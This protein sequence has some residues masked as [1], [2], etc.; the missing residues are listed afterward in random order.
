VAASLG[1]DPEKILEHLPALHH[2]LTEGL[3]P[4]AFNPQLYAAAR[5]HAEDM[6]E[7][8]YYSHDSQDGRTYEDRIRDTG[9]D[10]V[11][12][13]QFMGLQCLGSDSDI[14]ESGARLDRLVFLMFKQ[15]FT[16]E[17]N[18]G[19]G[20][21][22]ILNPAFKE[23]GV[24]VIEGTSSEL[25]GICGDDLLFTVADFGLSSAGPVP[26]IVGVVY[27]DMDQDLLCSP[28]EGV[29]RAYVS[30]EGLSG[31]NT[32]RR[33]TLYANEAGGFSLPALPGEYR[34]SVT[35]DGYQAVE[36]VDIEV[37]EENE[38]ILLGVVRS[39]PEENNP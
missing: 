32:S 3:P 35:A 19:A 9:Y 31:D 7:N 17:L 15:I 11:V 10:P 36:A 29:G 4:L 20:E 25:G 2:I 6:L 30:V 24:G 16:Y 37:G 38:A 22:S 34:I 13:G 1:M 27:S 8:G 14:D 18:P 23:V 12:M 21:R 39:D 33:F 5:S 26:G 28:G